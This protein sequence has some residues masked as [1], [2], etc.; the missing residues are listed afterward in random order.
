MTGDPKQDEARARLRILDACKQVVDA[1]YD[2]SLD[3]RSE[4][5]RLAMIRLDEI[6]DQQKAVET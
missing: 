4:V 5:I 6:D 1:L 2:L 3:S